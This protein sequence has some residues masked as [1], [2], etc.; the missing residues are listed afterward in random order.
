[1]SKMISSTLLLVLI[2][3]QPTIADTPTLSP[4]PDCLCPGRSSLVKKNGATY[5]IDQDGNNVQLEFWNC[6]CP[7]WA[8]LVLNMDRSM[9]CDGSAEPIWKNTFKV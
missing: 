1:M 2:L 8:M 7:T 6:T 9:S 4:E 5:C 3:S